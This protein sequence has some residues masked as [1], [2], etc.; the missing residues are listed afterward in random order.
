MQIP[1]FTGQQPQ[2]NSGNII[3]Q[4]AE[5]KKTMEG[6]DPEKIVREMLADGRMTQQQFENLKAQAQSLMTILR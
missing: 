2:K 5:F 4:F 3:Q 6:K 1:L